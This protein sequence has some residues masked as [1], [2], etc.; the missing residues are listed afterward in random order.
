MNNETKK[1]IYEAYI[2]P[3][4][5]VE[6]I[7]REFGLRSGSNISQ[8]ALAMGAELRRPKRARGS[9]RLCPKCR[10]SVEVKGAKFCPYCGTDIR[11]ERDILIERIDR[12][13]ECI[14]L[15]PEN[16]RDEVQK[17]FVDIVAEL[18]NKK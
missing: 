12:A 7:A 4:N 5:R 15:L 3:T 11:S 2:D 8:I 18:N 14:S 10:K 1:K 6:D 16:A 9:N 13:R 17:L